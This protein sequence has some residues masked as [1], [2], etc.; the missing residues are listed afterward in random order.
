MRPNDGFPTSW[1]SNRAS[2]FPHAG[3]AVY[4]RITYGPLANGDTVQAVEAGMK[5]FDYVNGMMSDSGN[6][7]VR[8]I[9]IVSSVG[10]TG[11]QMLTAKL[12]WIAERTATVGGQAQTTQTEAAASTDL[13]GETVRL[14]GIG[15]K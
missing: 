12:K 6:F 7:S 1:G 13:S 4:T 11:T 15:P 8:V 2:V 14:L 9:P 5:Y 3:P 10:P